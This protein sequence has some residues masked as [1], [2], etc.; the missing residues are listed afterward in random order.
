MRNAHVPLGS[1][2]QQLATAVLL[3]LGGFI[4]QVA[5]LWELADICEES[6]RPRDDR[7]AE[8]L[9]REA[10]E[11]SMAGLDNEAQLRIGHA[12]AEW[13]A[14]MEELPAAE[15]GVAFGQAHGTED[16]S[17]AAARAQGALERL[18]G[19]YPDIAHAGTFLL[20]FLDAFTAVSRVD[21]MY[22]SIVTAAVSAF[23]AHLRAIV[24]TVEHERQPEVGEADLSGM[25]DGL[26]NGGLPRWRRWL[27]DTVGADFPSD[28]EEISRLSEV[29]LR[30]NLFVHSGG[31]VSARYASGV[32]DAPRL[33]TRLS[34]DATYTREA[35]RGLLVSGVKLAV[36]AWSAFRP[37]FA[38]NAQVLAIFLTQRYLL[39]VRAWPAVLGVGTWLLGASLEPAQRDFA[40]VLAALS[41]KRTG[42]DAQVRA[43]CEPWDPAQPDLVLVRQVLLGQIDEAF[44]TARR[45]R[46]A[47]A[48]TTY[49]LD[50]WPA[51]EDLRAD[52]RWEQLRRA[53]G[54]ANGERP[55][56]EAP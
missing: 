16:A 21:A 23:H 33:G 41:A 44:E 25:V 50:T 11:G 40:R 39:R 27:H 14:A 32:R 20:G 35:L 5:A 19:A 37:P 22:E 2:D 47:G 3:S 34:A 18:L 30:R 49:D 48:L 53:E 56:P 13:I 42:D 38:S 52:P 10:T 8:E 26:I 17:A 55:H 7:S 54:G 43:L 45:L 36:T 31:V 51:L 12:G 4:A 46:E 9:V 6:V 28:S 29:F 24:L 1:A 15:L